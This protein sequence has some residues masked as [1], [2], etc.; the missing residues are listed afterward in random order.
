[1]TYR[2]ACMILGAMLLLS[3]SLPPAP[4][5]PPWPPRQDL[6]VPSDEMPVEGQI[7]VLTPLEIDA[8][9]RPI[10]YWVLAGQEFQLQFQ[11]QATGREPVPLILELA[12]PAGL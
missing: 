2:I 5:L 11:G 12:L 4:S 9:R 3:V 6:A 10:R 8:K 7:R 1:M